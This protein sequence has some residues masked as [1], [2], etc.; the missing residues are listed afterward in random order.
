MSDATKL[1]DNAETQKRRP[2]GL[3]R[4][5]R[6]ITWLAFLGIAIWKS[7]STSFGGLEFLA[8]AVAVAI[9][10]WCLAKPMGPHK[11]D[12]TSPAQV[13]GEFA[14]RT[15]WAW[16][17]VGA[18][19]TAAGVGGTGAIVYDLSSGRA[20]AGDVLTDIGV[21]IEGWFAEIFTKGFYDAELEKTRAYA[22]AILLIP[23]LLLLWYNLIP[24]RHRGKRFLVDD[25]GEVRTKVRDG[26]RS[27]NPHRFATVTADGTTITFDGARGEPK[28]VLPQ[29]RVYSVAHGVR[30]IDKVSAEFFTA[31]LG[32]RGFTVEESGPTG[33]TALRSD[34]LPTYTQPQ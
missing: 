28:L 3:Q 15:N 19:L 1:T 29:H 6:W 30:L 33:F 26:W 23:G 7:D 14:S 18:L 17:L 8:L 31:H 22:L 4:A 12:L 27:L 16:V 34:A 13:R 25:F 2:S 20:D 5:L 24:L 21:F 32:A 9:T 10:V 11:I